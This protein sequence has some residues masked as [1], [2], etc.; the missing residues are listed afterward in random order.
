M[1][2]VFGH[3]EDAD[4]NDPVPAAAAAAAGAAVAGAGAAAAPNPESVMML[5]SMGFTVGRCR[6]TLL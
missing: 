1:E 5:T 3:M 6:I 4:F 2:W